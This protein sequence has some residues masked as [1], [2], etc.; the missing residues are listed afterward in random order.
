MNGHE[1]GCAAKHWSHFFRSQHSESAQG[2]N[3][4]RTFIH[5]H[6]IGLFGPRIVRRQDG[7]RLGEKLL[8]RFN[9]FTAK[10]L[11]VGFKA[12]SVLELEGSEMLI[13]PNRVVFE[14]WD[15]LLAT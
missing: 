8:N 5:L 4:I 14:K 13:F 1:I 2:L 15:D 12:G 3:S 7:G 9:E 6:D 10:K 11:I